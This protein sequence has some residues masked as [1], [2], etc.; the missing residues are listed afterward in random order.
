MI[1]SIQLGLEIGKWNV[2]L[3]ISMV[4]QIDLGHEERRTISYS[5]I[6][7]FGHRTLTLLNIFDVSIGP[8][9]DSLDF[10]E[11]PG[12]ELFEKHYFIRL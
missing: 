4:Q 11:F 7:Y 12:C 8:R 2:S 1:K 3:C 9:G 10:V 6:G 5:F